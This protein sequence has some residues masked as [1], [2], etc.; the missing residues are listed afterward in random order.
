[1]PLFFQVL[2]SWKS[3]HSEAGKSSRRHLVSTGNLFLVSPNLHPFPERL[4]VWA[5]VFGWGR[6]FVPLLGLAFLN[7]TSS[8]RGCQ[9]CSVCLRKWSHSRH[10]A[11]NPVC[12]FPGR[13]LLTKWGTGVREIPRERQGTQ[14]DGPWLYNKDSGLPRCLPLGRPPDRGPKLGSLIECWF[15]FLKYKGFHIKPSIICEE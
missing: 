4:P 9:G 12:V 11:T 1:M 2:A 7:F 15:M 14:G 13:F 3:F 8:P 5:R 10:W 6:V